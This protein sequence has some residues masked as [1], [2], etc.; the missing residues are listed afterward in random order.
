MY[1]PASGRTRVSANARRTYAGDGA[2]ARPVKDA[3]FQ[4]VKVRPREQVSPS[5]L[6]WHGSGKPTP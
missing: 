3:V 4:P 5:S 1:P 6:E 2:L